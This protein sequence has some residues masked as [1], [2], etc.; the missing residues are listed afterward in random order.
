M[1]LL[2]AGAST[3]MRSSLVPAALATAA[4]ASIFE[5]MALTNLAP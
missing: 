1:G 5:M 2:R 4:I 3:L